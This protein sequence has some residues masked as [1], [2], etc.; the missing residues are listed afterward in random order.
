MEITD[1]HMVPLE[2]DIRNTEGAKN[3]GNITRTAEH[4]DPHPPKPEWEYLFGK[5]T[6]RSSGRASWPLWVP[7]DLNYDSTHESRTGE[8][9]PKI[10]FMVRAKRISLA[11]LQLIPSLLQALKHNFTYQCVGYIEQADK[12][13]LFVTLRPL[14]LDQKCCNN[15]KTAPDLLKRSL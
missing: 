8:K 7:S 5:I 1:H 2:A 13:V 3:R 9:H 14:H 10:S 12:P 6:C 15:L 11:H 4:K